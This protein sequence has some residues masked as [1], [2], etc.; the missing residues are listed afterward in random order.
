[1]TTIPADLV[2]KYYA[3]D[4]NTEDL[5]ADSSYLEDGMVVLVESPKLREDID[6]LGYSSNPVLIDCASVCNR[7]GAVSHIKRSRAMSM[8]S[9]ITTYADGTK[10]KRDYNETHA[11]FVKLDSIPETLAEASEAN[12]PTPGDVTLV[13]NVGGKRPL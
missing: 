1:M 11:W 4:P 12:L 6:A 2:G 10:R 7:W 3:M 9:F 5:L 8:V 13:D